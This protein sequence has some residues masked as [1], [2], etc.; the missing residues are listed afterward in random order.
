MKDF[1]E[2]T[3]KASA[4]ALAAVVLCFFCGCNRERGRVKSSSKNQVSSD[5]TYEGSESGQ[6]IFADD[7]YTSSASSPSGQS[8]KSSGSKTDSKI[9]SKTEKTASKVPDSSGANSAKGDN[10]AYS[11]SGNYLR[12]IWI[13]CYDINIKGLSRNDFYEKIKSVMKNISS[14]GYNAVFFHVR[15]FADAYYKSDYFPFSKYITGTQG[16]DPGY[17][18]LELIISSARAAGL[19]FHAWINPYRVTSTN[20]KT[21]SL[22]KSN[23]ALKWLADGSERAVK[24]DVGVYFNPGSHDAQAL[25]LNGIKEILQNYKVDGIHFDDYFY[26]T[27]QKSFDEKTYNAYRSASKQKALG[28][29]DW[30]RANVNALVSAAYRMCK[31]KGVLFGISPSADISTDRTDKNYIQNYADIALWMSREGYVDYIAPQL[32]FG[33]KHK[34]NAYCYNNLLKKWRA[35]PAHKNLRLYI[36]LAAYKTG[37]KTNSDGDEWCDKKADI[38]SRQ[39]VDAKTDGAN[40][41]IVFSYSS[42]MSENELNKLQVKQLYKVW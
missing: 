39:A 19:S 24:T 41:I 4:A 25:V 26:P 21:D 29:E 9:S 12:G 34:L 27:T 3:K 13:S 38:L 22:A 1:T 23:I 11:S 18:P 32:Y 31:S 42:A 17:D 15:P 6:N 2:I 5:L 28:L 35:M 8:E 36:G 33:Y 14:L 16:S 30:R 37:T 10:K 40:G 7:A 20:E